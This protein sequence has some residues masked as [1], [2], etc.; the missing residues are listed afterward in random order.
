MLKSQ[1]PHSNK[2]HSHYNISGTYYTDK[3][4]YDEVMINSQKCNTRGR[5]E[6]AIDKTKFSF[7]FSS[8]FKRNSSTSCNF[9][10]RTE[11]AI[12]CHR[13]RN[14]DQILKHALLSLIADRGFHNQEPCLVVQATHVSVDNQQE[15]SFICAWKTNSTALQ[16][17][18]RDKI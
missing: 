14:A 12:L 1:L 7:S 2:V 17:H 4:S 11:W 16:Q 6:R 10:Q 5:T 9:L 15:Q 18:R 8:C 3:K 13:V